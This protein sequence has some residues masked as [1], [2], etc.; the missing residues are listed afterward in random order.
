MVCVIVAGECRG[1][2]EK[3]DIAIDYIRQ[4]YLFTEN[5]RRVSLVIIKQTTERAIKQILQYM[6]MLLLL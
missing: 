5:V 6:L 1:K 4:H 3:L 2:S